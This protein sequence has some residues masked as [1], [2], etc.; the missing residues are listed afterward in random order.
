MITDENYANI[1]DRVYSVDPLKHDNIED[2]LSKEKT[3]KSADREF[4][5]LHAEGNSLLP[6]DNGMQAMAVAPIIDGQA[7]YNSIAVV[8]VATAKNHLLVSVLVQMLVITQSPL[9]NISKGG[10]V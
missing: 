5:V 6:T 7:D 4:I 9:W 2:E 1:S 10:F 3:F 8:A